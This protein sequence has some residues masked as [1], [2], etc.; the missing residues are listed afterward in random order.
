MAKTWAALGLLLLLAGAGADGAKEGDD[1][2]GRPAPPLGQ[3]AWVQGRVTD[4]DLR[5]KVVLVRW[6][7]DGCSLCRNTAPALNRLH[8]GYGGR[9]L[10]VL[11]IYH[12][13]PSPGPRDPARI[14]AAAKQL[15]FRFPVAVDE[16]WTALRRWW[17]D[18]RDRSF[19]SV[20]FLVD[21]SGRIRYVHPGGEYFPS[22]DPREARQNHDYGEIEG[23]IDRLTGEQ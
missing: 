1:L 3:L 5:G 15:G 17:L 13:K 10:V 9:G 2:L 7:T 4:Q 12:P 6:W 18:G 8:A 20:S 23:L 14:R 16:R 11:G 22:T 21:R 19:T